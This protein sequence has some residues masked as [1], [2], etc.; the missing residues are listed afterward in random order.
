MRGGW[1]QRSHQAALG[2]FL[3]SGLLSPPRLCSLSAALALTSFYRLILAT[4]L[5]VLCPLSSFTLSPSISERDTWQTLS[6]P[7]SSHP[8]HSHPCPLSARASVVVCLSSA[9]VSFLTE[10]RRKDCFSCVYTKTSCSAFS[11]DRTLALVR[12][13]AARLNR[14][15][16]NDWTSEVIFVLNSICALFFLMKRRHI[17]LQ[18]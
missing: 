6:V 13:C 15:Q 4:V 7:P 3:H 10:L 17:I 14:C 5:C 8:P 1:T 16:C 18:L 9:E 2:E 11:H 12:W